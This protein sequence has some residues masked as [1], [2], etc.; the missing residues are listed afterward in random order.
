MAISLT[1]SSFLFNEVEED[2]IEEMKDLFPFLFEPL[3]TGI[4]YLGYHL[5]PN[6]YG[7][8]DWDWLLQKVDRRIHC[9]AARWLS[10]GGRL[11]LA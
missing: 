3:D 11:T 9:W 7:R 5:K 4:K 6:C 1:K 8:A 2:L 10:L